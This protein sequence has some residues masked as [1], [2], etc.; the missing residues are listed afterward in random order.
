MAILNMQIFMPW[1]QWNIFKFWVLLTWIFSYLISGTVEKYYGALYLGYQC[2]I[3]FHIWVFSLPMCNGHHLLSTFNALGICS[4][5]FTK[6]MAARLNLYTLMEVSYV[7]EKKQYRKIQII[8]KDLT[9][10]RIITMYNSFPTIVILQNEL[11]LIMVS[12]TKD[13]NFV[14]EQLLNSNISSVMR[15]FSEVLSS[16]LVTEYYGSTSSRKLIWTT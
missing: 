8:C 2:T 13:P 1:Q 7:C 10:W 14:Q 12:Q 6:L 11:L 9:N 5:T 15:L 4:K 16:N 3:F